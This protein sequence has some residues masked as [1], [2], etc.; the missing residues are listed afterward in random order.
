MSAEVN[1][2][3]IVEKGELVLRDVEIAGVAMSI[4]AGYP[5]VAVAFG[6]A[7]A[8]DHVLGESL[9]SRRKKS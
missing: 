5:M 4:I 2:P 7:A 9:R 8:G 6:I 3:G 1:Q